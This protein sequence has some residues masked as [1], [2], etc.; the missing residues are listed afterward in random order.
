MERTIK[1]TLLE[2]TREDITELAVDAIV[3]AANT[4]L[5]L[6]G[7]VAGAIRRKGGPSIQDECDTKRPIAVGQAV[8]TA[9]GNLKA[10]YVIHAVGPRMSE[11][12]EGEKLKS[13][14]ISALCVA[15][16]NALGSIAFCAIST[17]V[18]GFPMERCAEIML[19]AIIGYLNGKTQLERVIFCLFD[20]K[21]YDTFTR[22][23]QMSLEK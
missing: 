11:G 5:V 10:K 8:I 6:G 17:G 13:A 2:L 14:A 7:G 16:E 15:D 22:Q 3:N 19:E 20:D 12:Q 9:A 4:Q 23:L 21:A 1:N 18:F